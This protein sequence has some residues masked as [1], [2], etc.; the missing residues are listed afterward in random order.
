MKMHPLIKVHGDMNHRDKNCSREDAEA[1]TLVNQVKKRFPHLLFMHIKNEGKKTKA[2]ADF[3]KAMG[4]LAGASD[5]VFLGTPPLL[6]EMKRKDNTL[7]T[8]QPNQQMFLLK[9]QE[10][11]CKVCVALGWEAAMEAVEDWMRIKK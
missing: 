8:W 9:A 1:M 7:S 3:D 5:F 11:G 6:L 10:Q 4:M 2:Q